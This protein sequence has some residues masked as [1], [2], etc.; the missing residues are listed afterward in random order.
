M[1]T[2]SMRLTNAKICDAVDIYSTLLFRVAFYHTNSKVEA[3][4]ITQEVFLSLVKMQ[5]DIVSDEH[6]KAW[7]IRST[8]NRCKNWFKSAAKRKNVALDEASL[9]TYSFDITSI[10]VLDAINR[11]KPLDKDI[12][13][14]HYYEGYS[15]KEIGSIVG[16]REDA[17]F[18]RLKRARQKLKEFLE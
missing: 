8:I 16:K 7:L 11:L 13:F 12:V 17:I 1:K 5:P 14:L 3:E 6:L 10:E 9:I 2:S 15:A 18:M 4:D